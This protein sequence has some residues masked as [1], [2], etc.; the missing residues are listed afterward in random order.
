MNQFI[1]Y[2]RVFV[3]RSF[4]KDLRYL[5]KLFR[6]SC[7]SNDDRQKASS[8]LKTQKTFN[9]TIKHRIKTIQM[10]IDGDAEVFHAEETAE[11]PTKI[12]FVNSRCSSVST[13]PSMSKSLWRK[14]TPKSPKRRAT[15][16]SGSTSS[17]SEEKR[18]KLR[19][20]FAFASYIRN[21]FRRSNHATKTNQRTY[22]IPQSFETN[23][24]GSAGAK[25]DLVELEPMLRKMSA[26]ASGGTTVFTETPDA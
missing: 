18:P 6:Q 13:K 14:W 9:F 4:L 7:F 10:N 2:L 20:L 17:S 1:I 15:S 11:N 23:V 12:T 21:K 19:P 24:I 26:N 3:S 5:M 8:P 16:S 22:L 25:P